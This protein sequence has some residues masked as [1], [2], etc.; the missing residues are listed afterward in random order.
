VHLT[1]FNDDGCDIG[2]VL[3]QLFHSGHKYYL[4]WVSERVNLEPLKVANIAS[5]TTQ[6]S[7]FSCYNSS[8]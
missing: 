8:P 7:R 2:I 5:D 1:P 3:L 4:C 6:I